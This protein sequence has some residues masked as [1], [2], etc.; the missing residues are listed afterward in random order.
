MQEEKKAQQA[1]EESKDS[2]EATPVQAA[3]ADKP[4]NSDDVEAYAE[5]SDGS[6]GGK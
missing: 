5:P 6:G 1:K 4:S 2:G 3:P